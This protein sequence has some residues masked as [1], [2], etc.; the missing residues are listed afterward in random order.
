[1]FDEFIVD[2][3]A[4][5]AIDD[6]TPPQVE[7]YVDDE[8]F[9][10]GDLVTSDPVLLVKLADDNGI[11]VSGAA[12]GHDLTA[13]LRGPQEATYVLNDFYQANTDDYRTGEVRYPIFDLPEGEYELEVRAWDVANNSALTLSSF[14]VA[15]DAGLALSRVLNYPNPFV[16]ATCF[17]F[18]HNATGRSVE[19]QVDIYTTSGRL[20]QSLRR[21]TVAAGTRFGNGD[22]VEWDGT[23]AFGQALARGV[24]L[25]KVKMRTVEGDAALAESGFEKLVVLR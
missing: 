19:V 8:S 4:P 6:E 3:L 20:V 11:N 12:I 16:D 21:E 7:V 14:I 5:P 1:M 9:A 22:C 17:Q 18:E 10:E 25:Y 13:K 15:A 2:G 23:D 24:Y